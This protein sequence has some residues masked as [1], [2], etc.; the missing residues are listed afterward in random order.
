MGFDSHSPLL[1]RRLAS[2]PGFFVE[3]LSLCFKPSSGD[4]KEDVPAHV[5]TNAYQLLDDWSVVP[6]S[7][8]QGEPVDVA[9]L[10]RW[11]DD[12]V[13]LLQT[14]DRERIGLEFIG[15]VL[16]KAFDGA[17]NG[18]PPVAVRE[19][20][21]RARRKELD[22]GFEIE[23]FNSRGATMRNLTDGGE[24][25]RVLAAKYYGVA[26]RIRD[27]WPRTGA[28]FQSIASSYSE[29]ARREDEEVKRHVEGLGR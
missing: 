23:V 29:H 17:D 12:A 6:G 1:E 14:A 4:S 24:Q 21:E 13:P 8:G 19:L 5:A 9:K 27:R 10:N 25:E 18:A 11:Y 26:E 20:I 22:T 15:R 7:D 16:A 28:I 2:D 3:V